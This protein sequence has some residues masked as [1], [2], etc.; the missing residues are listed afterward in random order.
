MFFGVSCIVWLIVKE[1]V[2][3]FLWV[4]GIVLGFFVV[5]LVCSIKV[6]WLWVGLLLFFVIGWCFFLFVVIFFKVNKLYIEILGIS[7]I[8][9]IFKFFV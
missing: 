2:V 1:F 5:L 8:I 9:C 3:K 6:I 4:K 7:L